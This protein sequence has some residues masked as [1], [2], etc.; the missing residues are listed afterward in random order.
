LLPEGDQKN[1]PPTSRSVTLYFLVFPQENIPADMHELPP[2]V[3]QG[4]NS[5]Q[6]EKELLDHE[7][8]F[9]R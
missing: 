7:G 5:Y 9:G 4:A 1:I 8:R 3:C 6:G 2:G